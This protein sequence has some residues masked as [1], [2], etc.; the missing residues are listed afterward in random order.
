MR[1]AAGLNVGDVPRMRDVRDVENAYAANPLLAHGVLHALT[2]AVDAS[3]VSLG[4]HEQQVLVDRD[5]ALR[6]GAIVADLESRL[7]RIRDIPDLI[8]VVVALNDVR[9]REG[10]VRVD[11]VGEFL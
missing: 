4:R 2:A 11:A 9:A 1:A 5:V 6:G 10:E 8:A 3:R 7:A